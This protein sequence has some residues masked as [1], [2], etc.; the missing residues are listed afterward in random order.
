MQTT[1]DWIS[2]RKSEARA[3]AKI[4]KFYEQCEVWGLEVEIAELGNKI[5]G[6][7]I[8]LAGFD[9]FALFY[10]NPQKSH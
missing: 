1:A 3:Q 4:M 8:A 7:N 6:L 9:Y 2:C 10:F 5:V